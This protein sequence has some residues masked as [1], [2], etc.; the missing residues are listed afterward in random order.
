MIQV[1]LLE[2]EARGDVEKH[3]LLPFMD[4]QEKYA[5]PTLD[6]YREV[7]GLEVKP[8]DVWRYFV[9]VKED[10]LT[11]FAS[12]KPFPRYKSEKGRG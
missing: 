2:P 12:Q 5:V 7:K 9:R 11:E 1:A 6:D 10:V 8:P 4:I 3:S